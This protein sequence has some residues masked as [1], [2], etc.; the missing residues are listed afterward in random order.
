MWKSF[1]SGIHNRD[2]KMGGIV[3]ERVSSQDWGAVFQSK[4]SEKEVINHWNSNS[5]IA[6]WISTTPQVT[7]NHFDNTKGKRDVAKNTMQCIKSKGTLTN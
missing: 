4:M 1:H 5:G 3:R 6:K 2:A 7:L